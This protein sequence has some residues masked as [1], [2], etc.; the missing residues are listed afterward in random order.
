MRSCFA[1]PFVR[2]RWQLVEHSRLVCT[3]NHSFD[4]SKNGYVNLAPQAHVTKYDKSLFEARKIVI[5]G[6]FFNPLLDYITESLASHFK[7]NEELALLDA[8]CGEGSHLSEIL[9]QLPD[10]V[11]GSRH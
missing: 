6:G 3:K 11:I 4:L 7:G 9:Q 5:D 1:V 2:R 8:G 10:D